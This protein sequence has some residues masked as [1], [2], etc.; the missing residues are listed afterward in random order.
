[1]RKRFT[2]I[3]VALAAFGLLTPVHACGPNTVA[4]IENLRTMDKPP[5]FRCGAEFNQMLERAHQKDWK[6][7]V[8]AYEA[9]LA[10]IG[11]WQAGTA[12]ATA[13]LAHL[14]RMAGAK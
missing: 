7:A 8:K 12:D 2:T 10:G 13:T 5:M 1:M 14:R 4:L 6:G 11:K 3:V 9:H